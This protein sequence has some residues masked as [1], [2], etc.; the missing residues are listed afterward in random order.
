ML[1]SAAALVAAGLLLCAC[2]SPKTADKSLP[3]ETPSNAP[4]AA[5]LDLDALLVRLDHKDALA[6]NVPIHINN[7]YGDVRLRFGGYEHVVE[8]HVT[9][10]RP[11]A[12]LPGFSYRHQ[13]DGDAYV[14]APQLSAGATLHATARTD[15]VVFV[16]LGH[17]VR[18]VTARGLVEGRGVKGDVHVRSE[19]GNI[20]L[21]GTA[22]LVD[23]HTDSG[24]I[25]VALEDALISSQQRLSTL[26]GAITA[27]LA[28]TANVAVSLASSAPLTTEFSLDI[29]RL[30]GQEPNK[31]ARAEI[32]KPAAAL[33]IHSKRGEI[34][35]LRRAAFT[36]VASS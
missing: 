1:R 22:G 36:P 15:L 24:S 35:L 25:E 34:R 10:Q 9:E 14:I 31:Q 4:V 3:V 18:V 29:E 32:G 27:V 12:D 28:D 19:A 23:L 30:P 16:P 13:M 26:T 5:A 17:A 2:A 21:R 11:N 8:L 33:Q 20:M 7:P 6:A